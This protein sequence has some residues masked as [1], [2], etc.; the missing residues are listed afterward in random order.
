MP[1]WRDRLHGDPLPW[2]LEPDHV[3]PAIRYFALRDLLDRGTDD[4]EVQEAHA[5]VM[6]TGSVPAILA[7]QKPEG[8][9]VKPGPGYER[10]IGTTAQVTFLAQLGADGS[11]PRVQA[12]CEYVLSHYI[13]SHGGISGTG[14]PSNFVHCHAGNLEAAL[15]DLGWLDD[16]R[17]Q[18][19]LEWHARA[20]TGHEVASQDAKGTTEK[21]YKSGTTGPGFACAVNVGLPCG[22]GAIKALLAFSKVPSRFRTPLIEKALRQGVEFLFSRDPAIADYPF[23]M[24]SKPSGNWF[25]FGYPMSYVADV[26]Q[27]LEVLAALGHGQDTRLANALNLVESKQD[28]QGRWSLEYTLNGK[29]WVD[30]ETKGKPSKWITLRALRVLKAAYP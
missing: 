14:A 19:A 23:G 10:Y 18:R 26:L 25:K 29:M 7:A 4:S 20:V 15:I 5:T 16:L 21:Y 1:T 3:Q 24:G 13:A 12:A 2:L 17:L 11:D 28:G 22:W 9:W 8:Y 6:A 30:I 27:N